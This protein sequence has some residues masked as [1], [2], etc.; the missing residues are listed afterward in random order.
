MSERSNLAH[1]SLEI[2]SLK[3]C[4]LKMSEKS[5]KGQILVFCYFMTNFI[6]TN[7]LIT[8]LYNLYTASWELY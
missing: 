6:K 5:E 7:G 8:F 2:N 3:N 1:I 4:F